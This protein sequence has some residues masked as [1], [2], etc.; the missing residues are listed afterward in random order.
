VQAVGGALRP[1]VEVE[2][3]ETALEVAV[4]GIADAITARSVLRRQQPRL[5]VPLFSAP[6]RPRLHDHFA[7]VHRPNAVLSR[8]VQAVIEMATARMREVCGEAANTP[9]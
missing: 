7:I 4:M 2:N 5:A 3:V 1:T 6:L 9:S 8:P